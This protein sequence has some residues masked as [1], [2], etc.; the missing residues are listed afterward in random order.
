[1]G[2]ISTTDKQAYRHNNT[3]ETLKSIS[4]ELNNKQ[5]QVLVQDLKLVIIKIILTKTPY[6]WP[7]KLFMAESLLSE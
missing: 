4:L 6:K 5:D 3:T 1:M 2:S 7:V